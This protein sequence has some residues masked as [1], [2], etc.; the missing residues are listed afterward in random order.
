MIRVELVAAVAGLKGLSP[1]DN[2]RRVIAVMVLL[3]E[4][5]PE[6]IG[7]GRKP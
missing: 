3:E 2:Y 6:F 7:H 1:T 5:L 4:V